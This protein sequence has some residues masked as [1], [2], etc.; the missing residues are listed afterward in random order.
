MPEIQNFNAGAKGKAKTPSAP[1]RVPVGCCYCRC[2]ASARIP[3]SEDDGR[4]KSG[5]HLAYKSSCIAIQSMSMFTGSGFELLFRQ[6]NYTHWWGPALTHLARAHSSRSVQV[7]LSVWHST[8]HHCGQHPSTRQPPSH[9]ESFACS[10]LVLLSPLQSP[11]RIACVRSLWPA[12]AGVAST[13]APSAMH[14]QPQLR[15]AV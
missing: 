1:S 2:R 12:R 10:A 8:R 4:Q 6:G 7:Q 13:R 15:S 11:L 14:R 9:S 3:C 5:W